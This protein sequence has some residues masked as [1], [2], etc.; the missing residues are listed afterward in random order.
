V[1]QQE[2]G[3]DPG[4]LRDDIAQKHGGTL[5]G[6]LRTVY[7]PEFAAG[8]DNREK[9]AEVLHKMDQASVGRLVRDYTSGQLRSKLLVRSGVGL[10]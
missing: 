2:R 3:R 6:T 8:C 9:L 7:G 10:L 4:D 5:V 1:Q